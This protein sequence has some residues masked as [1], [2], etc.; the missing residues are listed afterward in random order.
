[1]KCTEAIELLPAAV[2]G[3]IGEDVLT[4]L[5]HHLGECSPCLHEFELERLTKHV[6]GKYSR[7]SQ[8]PSHLR[9]RILHEVQRERAASVNP[10]ARTISWRR[11]PRVG[12]VAL[13]GVGAILLLLLYVTPIRSHRHTHAQPADA[14]VVHQT[15]NNF[16]EVL[17]GHIQPEIVTDDPQK[18]AAFFSPM[19]DFTVQFPPMRSYKLVG[20][21]CSQYDDKCIAQLVYRNGE[22]VVYIY[23]VDLKTAMGDGQGAKISPEAVS[24]LKKSGW[25]VENHIPDCSL[26]MWIVDSTLC[27]AVADINKDVLLASLA[28]S[29]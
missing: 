5:N 4:K 14:D 21:L 27:C 18:I 23:E 17:S 8:P 1:V 25:Y 13:G 15:Y 7:P 6:I 28:V 10:D 24:Q 12:M 26:A 19:V 16:D 2:D 3:Q 20:A 11:F 22:D 29:R 9:T